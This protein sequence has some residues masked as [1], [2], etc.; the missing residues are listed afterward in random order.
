[1][2]ICGSLIPSPKA[3]IDPATSNMATAQMRESFIEVSCSPKGILLGKILPAD[4]GEWPED[5][6]FNTTGQAETNTSS[7]KFEEHVQT[8]AHSIG[9][10]Q[11]T[12]RYGLEG[13]TIRRQKK[14]ELESPGCPVGCAPG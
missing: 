6:S 8:V 5:S 10:M 7:R 13:C 4:K 12:A 2:M 11:T 14:P 1:M 9:T 3:I